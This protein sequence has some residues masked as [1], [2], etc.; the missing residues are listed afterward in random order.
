VAHKLAKINMITNTPEKFITK[1]NHTYPPF[2]DMIFEEYFY[3]YYKHNNIQ[4]EREYLPVLWTNFY[5]S[6]NYAENNCSDMQHFIDDLDTSKKY[7]TVLQYDDGI[8]QNINHLDIKVFCGGGGGQKSV[9]EKNLGYPIP[10]L[11]KP[12]PNIN[13]NKERNILCSFMGV[14][15]RHAVRN[16]MVNC[17]LTKKGF[18]LQNSGDYERFKD[19]ME[20]SIFSLCPRGYGATSFRICESLQHGSIPVYLYDKPWIPWKDEFDFNKIG[21]LCHKDEI[22]NLPELL[23]NKTEEDI[24]EYKENGEKIYKEYFDY[25][26]CSK[27]IIT[28]I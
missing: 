24:K 13:K 21:I 9:P 2:N 17:L 1:T 7:F 3:N 16:E 5:I 4:T 14:I 19:I 20:R 8:L 6:R 10:L 12:D 23:N 22:K 11:C 27:K 15:N 25:E 28:K 18:L 26:G